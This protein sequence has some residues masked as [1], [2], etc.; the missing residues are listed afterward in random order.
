[1]IYVYFN[2]DISAK[3]S[4]VLHFAAKTL[5]DYYASEMSLGIDMLNLIENAFLIISYFSLYVFHFVATTQHEYYTSEM[6][7]GT[8]MLSL[9]L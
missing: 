9:T 6:C 7:L 1:M 4:Y 5:H 3:G 8:E 2:R